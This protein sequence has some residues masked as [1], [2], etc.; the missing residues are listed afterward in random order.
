M[1]YGNKIDDK[2]IVSIVKKYG[3]DEIFNGLE[4]GLMSDV[5]N[6][7]KSMSG[8]MQKIIMNVRGILKPG[9]VIVFDEPLAG[10]DAVSRKKMI[11]MIDEMTKGKTLIVITHDKEIVGIMNKVINL[12]QLKNKFS[13]SG[14]SGENE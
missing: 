8:G 12:Q 10:L 7:G 9:N 11:K 1:K 13:G 3:L 2:K 6:Q 14:G 5:G 4:K